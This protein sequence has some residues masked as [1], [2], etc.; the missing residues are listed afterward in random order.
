MS[1][2]MPDRR[3]EL[4]IEEALNGLSPEERVEID[5][6]LAGADDRS[7]ERA[8]AAVDVAMFARAE[9]LPTHLAA[10]VEADALS[11]SAGQTTRA[12]GAQVSA[13]PAPRR[14]DWTR[15][16]GWMAAAA[17]FAVAGAAWLTRPGPPA[18]IAIVVPPAPSPAV[19]V[20]EPPPKASVD[21]LRQEVLAARDVVRVDW[22]ATKDPAAH[23]AVGDVVWSESLQRGFMR[24]RGLAINDPAHSQYQLWIFDPTQDEKTPIDGG[25][26]DVRSA[27]ED[28]I[29]PIDP[30]L[31]VTRPT[32]F[33]VTVEKPGGVVVSKR[34]RIVVVASVKS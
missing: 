30:K 16:A 10:K 13:M 23:D 9:S 1:E 17:S 31:H 22:T 32:L 6:L 33:A 29:V 21:E 3:Y 4:L 27:N 26:F 11:R 2:W 15:W 5:S 12:S 20:E 34:K 7:F 28:L 14:G 18:P 25:V 24:F 19:S 8:A